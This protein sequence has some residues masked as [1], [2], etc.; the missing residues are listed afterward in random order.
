MRFNDNMT[1]MTTIAGFPQG[2]S[3]S[4]GDTELAVTIVMLSWLSDRVW[5]NVR[6]P[7]TVLV[8]PKEVDVVQQKTGALALVS[9]ERTLRAL[10]LRKQGCTYVAIAAELGVSPQAVHKR[11]AKVLQL[12]HEEVEEEG[13][14][15]RRLEAERL[16]ALQLACWNQAMRGNLKAVEQVLRIMDRRARLLGLDQAPKQ[17]LISITELQERIARVF[18]GYTDPMPLADDDGTSLPDWWE[19]DHPQ[20]SEPPRIE[21]LEH[22]A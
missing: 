4:R 3:N 14:S 2:F 9:G 20:L 12:M 7:R 18:T 8:D 16:D 6:D 15:L 13:K 1:S 21:T 10:E 17:E 5:E 22:A 19:E 11:V